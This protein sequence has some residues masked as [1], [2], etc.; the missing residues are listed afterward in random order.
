MQNEFRLI[1]AIDLL[2]NRVVRLHQ[3][4]YD[5]VT[6]YGEDPARFVREFVDAG[7]DLIHIV[8]LNAARDGD[9]AKNRE[10]INEILMATRGDAKL[11]IGGGI[12][13]DEAVDEYLSR[14]VSR[15][16]IGTSAVSDRE[17][18]ERTVE[19]YGPEIVIVG[20]DARDGRVRVAGWEQDSGVGVDEFVLYLEQ[21]GIREIIFTDIHTDGA[22]SGPSVGALRELMSMSSLRVI[23]SGGI[24]SLDDVELLL[25]LKRNIE[26]DASANPDGGD[27]LVGAISGRAVYERKLDLNGA[28]SLINAALR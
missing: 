8:D 12:R 10:A 7:A 22:M 28:F 26:S 5:A 6:E 27:R 17:F 9:R 13:S 2:N 23:A 14:G 20:V 16:I 1:P 25:Q 4:R 18:L 21:I 24:S 19:R 15:C 3:G 11:E